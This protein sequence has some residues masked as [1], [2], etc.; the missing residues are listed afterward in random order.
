MQRKWVRRATLGSISS[1]RPS[2]E[3]RRS[4]SSKE[5]NKEPSTFVFN[6]NEFSTTVDETTFSELSD[7]PSRD[8]PA[9][10]DPTDVFF[11]LRRLL[12]DNKDGE[13]FARVLLHETH[14]EVAAIALSLQ[15]SSNKTLLYWA[16]YLELVEAVKAMIS[17]QVE[18]N[19]NELLVALQAKYGVHNIECATLIFERMMECNP[20][21]RL[22]EML[23]YKAND[24]DGS[25]LHTAVSYT[26]SKVKSNPSL[27]SSLCNLVS[28]MLEA[29]ASLRSTYQRGRTVLHEC[30]EIGHQELA[31][32]ILEYATRSKE[33]DKLLNIR[34]NRG[35]TCLD[36]LYSKEDDNEMV[37]IFQGAL[38]HCRIER[39]EKKKKKKKKSSRKKRT[40]AISDHANS[41]L[42]TRHMSLNDVSKPP[43]SVMRIPPP[44]EKNT[45]LSTII[46]TTTTTAA[47]VEKGRLATSLSLAPTYR[48]GVGHSSSSSIDI[49]SV[50][51]HSSSMDE[52]SCG[53][54]IGSATSSG[55]AALSTYGKGVSFA[56]D[57]RMIN[58]SPSSSLKSDIEIKHDALLVEGKLL[59]ENASTIELMRMVAAMR[60]IAPE[61]STAKKKMTRAGSAN[62]TQRMYG[63]NGAE[64]T[65]KLSR[66]S[67]SSDDLIKLREK[68]R[69]NSGGK[70]DASTTS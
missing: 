53:S 69:R 54:F 68:P 8:K 15:D 33:L 64:A 46:T 63:V 37:D 29:G 56:S 18:V 28:M 66:K 67:I 25:A 51:A 34:D 55:G 4:N 3:R 43:S 44:K 50:D 39:R 58:S 21:M 31:E 41:S 14:A 30:C 13:S 11:S 61:H 59:L 26:A 42:R 10:D 22:M 27:T 35:K 65:A 1:P 62:S 2:S 47:M 70:G 36:L 19:T 24:W 60:N 38:L 57:R 48:L 6:L 12:V 7:A 23:N 32:T 49:S 9:G 17:I 45:S 16:A 40:S 5:K 20:P 52:G